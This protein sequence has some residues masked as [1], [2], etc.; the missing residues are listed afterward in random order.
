MPVVFTFDIE[1][2]PPVERNRIQSFFERFGWQNIGGSSY[3]YPRLGTTDQPVEDWLNHIIPA[4]MLFRTY[5]LSSRRRVPLFTIDVQSSA[6]YSQTT[7]QGT[8]ARP[9]NGNRRMTLYPPANN[10]FGEANLRD[11]LDSVTFPYPVGSPP[12]VP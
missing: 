10:A 1:G 12:S 4:L 5:I 8:R 9:G 2:A 7:L 11:W 6:G 3:R